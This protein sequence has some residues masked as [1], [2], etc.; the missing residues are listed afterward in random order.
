[1]SDEAKTLTVLYVDDEPDNVEG[2]VINVEDFWN[3]KTFTA[4][5]RI[6]AG[7]VDVSSVQVAFIDLVLYSM[8]DRPS[9]PLSRV[10]QPTEG[11]KLLHWFREHHPKIKLVVVSALLDQALTDT[12][13]KLFPGVVCIA[14][15]YNFAQPEFR[16][17]IE[18]LVR[19]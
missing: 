6:L 3:V 19:T 13:T 1:M 12:I 10:P 2:F 5:D 17:Q 18:A 7:E 9:S 4:A 8:G 15:P 11:F 14:K 16:K